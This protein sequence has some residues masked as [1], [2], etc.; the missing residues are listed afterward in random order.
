MTEN[1]KL[2]ITPQDNI[3][4]FITLNPPPQPQPLL[5]KNEYLALELTKA[6][7]SNGSA[8]YTCTIVEGYFDIL[9]RLDKESKDE[10]N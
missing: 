7:F 2:F 6:W 5:S 3:P 8:T 9:K 1:K 10:P 4:H